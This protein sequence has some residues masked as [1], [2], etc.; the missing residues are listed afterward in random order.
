M[1][2]RSKILVSERKFTVEIN[3]ENYI[4]SIG[5]LYSKKKKKQ[6]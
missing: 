1:A 6:E 3:E 4:G 2:S 5:I